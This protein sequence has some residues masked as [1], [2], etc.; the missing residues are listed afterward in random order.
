LAAAETFFILAALEL[1]WRW[2]ARRWAP[3]IFARHPSLVVNPA[4]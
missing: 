4:E 2:I 1:I 3:G